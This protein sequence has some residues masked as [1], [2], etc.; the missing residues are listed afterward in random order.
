[1]KNIEEYKIDGKIFNAHLV[2][3]SPEMHQRKRT[4][5]VAG[6]YSGH[7]IMN[8]TLRTKGWYAKT[9]VKCW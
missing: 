1:M 9:V 8:R 5:A 2:F 4:T 7:R 3:E 6:S